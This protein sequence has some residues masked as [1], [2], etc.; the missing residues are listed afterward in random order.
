MNKYNI[1]GDGKI[2]PYEHIELDKL[3]DG[4]TEPIYNY[5]QIDWDQS[6]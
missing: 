4:F 1:D 6:G 3:K 5:K 2:I